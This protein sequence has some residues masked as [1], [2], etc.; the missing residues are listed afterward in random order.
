MSQTLLN[1]SL[2]LPFSVSILGLSCPINT[3]LSNTVAVA[4]YTNDDDDDAASYPV[5]KIEEEAP[6]LGR[7]M[8]DGTGERRQSYS[9]AWYECIMLR[10]GEEPEF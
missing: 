7:I 8:S 10:N 4:F 9:Y 5:S 2:Y 6:T 1:P 3:K